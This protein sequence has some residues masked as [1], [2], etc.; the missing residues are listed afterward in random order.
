MSANT[1]REELARLR[2]GKAGRGR[3]DAPEDRAAIP[4]GRGRGYRTT[5]GGGGGGG[6]ISSPLTEIDG[7]RTYHA[8]RTLY[9]SDGLFTIVYTPIASAK[10]QDGDGNLVEVIYA[11]EA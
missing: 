4:A 1:I 7:E 6:G 8:E 5:E 9:S 10:F 11:D 3:L 2:P